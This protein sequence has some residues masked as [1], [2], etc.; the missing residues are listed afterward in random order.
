VSVQTIGSDTLDR[1]VGAVGWLLLRHQEKRF[2]VLPYPQRWVVFESL[3]R[4]HFAFL[5]GHLE[6]RLR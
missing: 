6:T 3:S 4:D 5:M 1:S 2:F